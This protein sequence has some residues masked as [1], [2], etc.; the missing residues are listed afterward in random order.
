MVTPQVS[1]IIPT[2]NRL[3]FLKEAT[4]S[5]L[6]QTFKDY[7]L[8]ISDNHSTDGT[9][10][11]TQRLAKKNP[12]VKYFRNEKNLGM[13][14]N[15]NASIKKAQGDY[16][17]IL[18]DDD[19][20][21]PQFL[22][23]T[24]RILEKETDVGLVCVQVIPQI[25][26]LDPIKK[27]ELELAYPQDYYRLYQQN[28]KV[29]GLDCI[30]QYLTSQWLVGLP[31]AVL[32]RK[33][34]FFKLGKFDP[35]GLDPEMWLRICRYYHFYYLD[36][37]LCYWRLHDL[38]GFTSALGRLESSY[39]I[40]YTIK[41]NSAYPGARK[42]LAKRRDDQFRKVI[43][44]NLFFGLRDISYGFCLHHSFTWFI[45]DLFTLAK[46]RIL[47]KKIG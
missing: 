9:Q 39:R 5:V 17:T 43:S 42:A 1:V 24:T 22:Q 37:K 36:Q 45:Q 15:W 35:V 29:K 30:K 12:R 46:T 28:K 14:A 16:V 4:Q 6:D 27:K 26:T 31:S 44:H 19:L 41:K 20:W 2:Y 34:C 40:L 33:K 21:K 3:E 13:A 32:V 10:T 25:D 11:W 8:I 7:E 23:E 38:E 18:M 47:G